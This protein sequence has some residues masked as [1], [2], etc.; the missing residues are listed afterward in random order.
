M[1]SA[2]RE[3]NLGSSK[4]KEC[5]YVHKTWHLEWNTPG[6]TGPYASGG[7]SLVACYRD[8]VDTM[9]LKAFREKYGE[10]PKAESKNRRRS[11]ILTIAY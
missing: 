9:A 1:G 8:I 11:R 3:K 7:Q 2:P 10:R 6:L 5:P 4:T